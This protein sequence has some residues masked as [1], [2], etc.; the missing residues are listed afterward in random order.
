MSGERDAGRARARRDAVREGK[1]TRGSH[2]SVHR[3]KGPR[4]RT[5]VAASGATGSSPGATM[6]DASL[7]SSRH[8]NKIHS[9]LTALPVLMLVSGLYFYYRGESAQSAGSPI[10]A[11]SVETHGAYT[12]TSVVKSGAEGRHYLWFDDGTRVRG[13]RIRPAQRASLGALEPGD[14]I[15]L[16]LAPTVSGSRTLWAWR[17][18]HAGTRFIDDASR[19]R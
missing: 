16:R 4:Y 8:K 9:I 7:S 5:G 6:D 14:E 17:V 19:L 3:A 10:L 13:V 11:E 15:A 12:G 2:A 18:E 1:G